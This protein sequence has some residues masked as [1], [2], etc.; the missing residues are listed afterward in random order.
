MGVQDHKVGLVNAH[1][2]LAKL[3]NRHLQVDPDLTA[4]SFR[5]G[6]RREH[7]EFANLSRSFFVAGFL[8]ARNMGIGLFKLVL[9][10]LARIF[11]L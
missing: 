4:E 3:R 2:S 9:D 10:N 11:P 1:F 8:N 7:P 6:T 5:V